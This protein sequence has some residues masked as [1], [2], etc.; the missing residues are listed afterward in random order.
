MLSTLEVRW[1][2]EGSIP[3]PVLNWFREHAAQLETQP[4]RVDYYLRLDNGDS[5]GIK[6]REGRIEVK[7]R[8]RQFGIVQFHDRVA[9]KVEAWHKISRELGE[10]SDE[11]ARL[12]SPKTTWIG[13]GKE[14]K[15][16]RFRNIDLGKIEPTPLSE[17][18]ERGCNLELTAVQIYGREWWTM[19]FEAFGDEINLEQD[20]SATINATLAIG[21][22][23]S[24]DAEHS[25]G[26]P[27]W[28]QR[29]DLRKEENRDD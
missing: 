14:R 4:P 24:L 23:P 16:L 21:I 20:L 6:L 9:G 10:I 28:L 13:V 8:Q 18:P 2:Y 3:Q 19:G 27:R 1:F 17:R 15:V 22:P 7:E 26:Y 25:F 5:Q 12:A 29:I 11:L